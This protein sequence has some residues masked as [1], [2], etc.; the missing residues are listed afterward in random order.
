MF[1]YRPQRAVWRSKT[2]LAFC[3]GTPSIALAAGARAPWLSGLSS[4]LVR[5]QRIDLPR[6]AVPVSRETFYTPIPPSENAP[7]S[8][9]EG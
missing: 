7:P 9:I 1:V 3:T 5:G 8:I 2:G 4:V 6:L